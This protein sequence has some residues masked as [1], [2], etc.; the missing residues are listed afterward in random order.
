MAGVGSDVELVLL[1]AEARHALPDPLDRRDVPGDGAARMNLESLRTALR[2]EAETEAAKRRTE[3][4]EACERRLAEAQAKARE[5]TEQGRL[6]GAHVAARKSL[7]RRAAANR[8]AREL[9]LAAQRGLIDELRLRGREA[10][11]ELRKDPRY[12][13]LLERLSQAAKSQLG[14]D[15]E[16]ES[17][18]R[19][20][21]AS[22]RAPAVRLSITRFPPS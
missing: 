9:R 20:S 3:V 13:E 8:R 17:T 16:V 14:A 18:R 7:R 21:A 10:A 6:E 1:T 19:I 5:L 2:V 22:S 12:E 11:L 15:A 4:D